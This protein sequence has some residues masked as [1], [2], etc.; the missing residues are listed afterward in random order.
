MTEVQ[1]LIDEENESRQCWKRCKTTLVGE[2]RQ[3][4]WL[5]VMMNDGK[6]AAGIDFCAK[7]DDTLN[8]ISFD[9]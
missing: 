8:A 1:G 5:R 4:G 2:K 3:E 9:T 6:R 7:N